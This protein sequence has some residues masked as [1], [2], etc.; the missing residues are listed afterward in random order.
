MKVGKWVGT[1]WLAL[2]AQGA[3]ADIVLSKY[4]RVYK[5]GEGAVVTLIPLSPETEKKALIKVSGIDTE[6]DGL[7]LLYDLEDQGSDEAYVMIYDG[8]RVARV[9]SNKESWTQSTTLYLPNKRDGIE[10]GYDEKASKAVKTDAIL[11]LYLT[12][13]VKKIQEGLA[14]FKRDKHVKETDADIGEKAK[15]ASNACGSNIKA[16]IDWK[17]ISD[18]YL[19]ELSITAFCGSPLEGLITLCNEAPANKK[20][21]TAKIEQ[22]NCTMGDKIHID[23]S[24]K[25]L[26]WTTTKDTPN[27]DDFAKYVLMNEL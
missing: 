6:V 1:V 8:S 11:K 4:A 17:S 7:V 20:T 23:I 19:K 2:A 25:T 14:Q 16:S 26:R 22:V 13:N 27:Q 21:L 5:G 10:I 18:D 3:M 9:R 15:Q 12:Q 24:A